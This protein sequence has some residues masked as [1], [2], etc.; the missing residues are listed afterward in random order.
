[1]ARST[2][3]SSSTAASISVLAGSVKG[4]E[5]SW[6]MN[7]VTGGVTSVP[8]VGMRSPEMTPSSV[9]L[10]AP[11]SPMSPVTEPDETAKEMSVSTRWP[12][13]YENEIPSS[14]I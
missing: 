8:A 2:P 7:P 4:S 12:S 6:A 1:M 10:P 14:P 3:R 11:F 13:G 9:D 5:V